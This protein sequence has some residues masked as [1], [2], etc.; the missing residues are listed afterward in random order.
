MR[1]LVLLEPHK[2]EL[3]EVGIPKVGCND[4]LIRVLAAAIC[5]TDFVVMEGQHS[6]ARYPC[7]LGHEFSGIVESTGPG[8][9]GLKNGA[10][11]TA[12]SYSYCGKCPSCR[13]GIHNGCSNIRG[14]PF[15]IEGAFQEYLSIP[16][17]MVFPIGCNLSAEE[18]ALTEPAA[19]GYAVADRADIYP[20]DKVVVIGPGPIGLL[21]LQFASLRHPEILIMNGTRKE[22]LDMASD[23][24]ATHTINV[25]D[26][27]PYKEIMEITSG[28]GADAVL[29]CGGGQDAWEMAESILAPFG[30][31]IVEALPQT[32]DT[33]WPVSVFKFTSHSIGFL[34]VSGYNGAQF[35]A[36]LKLMDNKKI[37][38]ASLITHRFSLEEYEKA[39][40]ASLNREDGAIKVIFNIGSE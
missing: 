11:V 20:G 18:A 40:N 23:L 7:V 5:H 27:D 39:F 16:A 8:V 9:K 36:A 14:I 17:S 15:G 29:F 22:R 4:A 30:K 37:D 3:Q 6:W 19:N 28:Y 33:K 32:Y 31:I 34:G 1:S 13:R 24:G 38:A 12:M 21:A 25:K 26:K 10:R 35:G 2:L